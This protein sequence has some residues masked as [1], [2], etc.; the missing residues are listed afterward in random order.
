MSMIAAVVLAALVTGAPVAD[1]KTTAGQLAGFCD[2]LDGASLARCSAFIMPAVEQV[3]D[4]G[5]G[6]GVPKL[7]VPPWTTFHQ[8]RAMFIIYVASHPDRARS[9]AVIVTLEMLADNFL[10][11]VN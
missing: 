3:K 4:P 2:S 6:T 11:P 10:C 1:E 8:L 9:Q 7:C 5:P